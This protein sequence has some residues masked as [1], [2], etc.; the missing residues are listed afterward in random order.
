MV[1][2]SRSLAPKSGTVIWCLWV[3]VVSFS[4]S[5][6]SSLGPVGL[7]PVFYAWAYTWTDQ[8]LCPRSAMIVPC[9][10]WIP[11]HFDEIRVSQELFLPWESRSPHLVCMV[12]SKVCET[13]PP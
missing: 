4:P 5:L 9:D 10:M 8:M 6:Y 2:L 7:N 13:D 3:K 12:A 11:L 1:V